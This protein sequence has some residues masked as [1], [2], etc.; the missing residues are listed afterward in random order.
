MQL[1]RQDNVAYAAI[2][3][4]DAASPG[5]VVITPSTLAIGAAALVDEGNLAHVAI[6]T[7]D[8]LPASTRL[9]VV[10]NIAGKLVFSAAFTKGAIIKAKPLESATVSKYVAPDQQVTRIG[11]NGTIGA[12]PTTS[13]NSNFFIRLRKR[14]NDAANRSQPNS[15]YAQFQTDVDGTQEEL[16]LGLVKNGILNMTTQPKGNNGY[17]RFE[18]LNAG[19]RSAATATAAVTLTF[20]K[21]STLVTASAATASTNIVAGDYVAIAAAVT[22][23]VYKVKSK[24]G[25]GNLT[26]ETAYQ[27]ATVA[28]VASAANIR[29]TNALAIVAASGVQM[30]GV[31]SDFDVNAFRNYMTIR[32]TATF[33]DTTTKVTHVTGATDG[34]G[35]W[36]QVAMD[37]YMSMGNQGENQMLS[38]PPVMRTSSVVTD[39]QYDCVHIAVKEDINGLVS[40]E[41]AD[42]DIFVFI[43]DGQGSPSG[44]ALAT[45][46]GV[47][48]LLTV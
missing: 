27:S 16:A 21:D 17:I 44:R 31:A 5:N 42:A 25:S 24:D 28:I 20:T 38:V 12:L 30:T 1:R 43:Q 7:Y 11:Y 10:Q 4:T 19:T 41:K 29:I 22:T 9:R 6:L 36:Q 48:T 39:G 8:A 26:L 46:L 13:V 35:T 40:A 33:S 37:E 32:F 23:G 34:T 18:M 14:D 2:A 45:A 47:H 15:L 3:D